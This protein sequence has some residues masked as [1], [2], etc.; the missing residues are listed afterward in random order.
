LNSINQTTQ[1]YYVARVDH[2]WSQETKMFVRSMFT[3][4]QVTSTPQLTGWGV[5]DPNATENR[6]SRHNHALNVTHLFSPAFFLSF[7]MG[8]SRFGQ[9]TTS[10]GCCETDFAQVL[11]IPNTAAASFPYMYYTGGLVPVTSVGNASS[12]RRVF[13][14]NIEWTGNLT[15]IVGNH[16]LKFGA[17]HSRHQGNLARS[18]EPSMNFSPGAKA[19]GPGFD[20]RFTRGITPTGA[21]VANTGLNLADFLLGRMIGV[22]ATLAPIFGKRI[23]Y[24][25]GYF[26]DDWRVTPRLTLNLG[27]R[28]DTETPMYE[29][30]DRYATFLPYAPNPLAGTGDI[31]AGATGITLFQNRNGNGK[32]LTNWDMTNF[33]PRFGFAYRLFGSNNTSLR[34]GFGLYYGGAGPDAAE[35]CGFNPFSITYTAA[36]PV[37]FRLRDGLP[38]GV[39]ALPGESELTPT[40][41]NRGTRFEQGSAVLSLDTAAVTPYSENFNLTVQ[42]QW[43]GILFEVGYRGNLSRQVPLSSFTLN[44][45][46]KELLSHTEIPA[47]LRRPWTVFASDEAEVRYKNINW[48]VANY[49]A[50]IFKSEYRFRNG[51]G[52]MVA[53]TKAKQLDNVPYVSS[54]GLGDNDVP[55]D[56]NNRKAEKSRSTG[57]LAHRLVFAPMVDLPFGKGRRW[58]N[59][60]GV[61]N[62]VLGGWQI[63]TIGTLQ[64]GAPF[65]VS[66]LN[67]GRDLLGDSLASLRPDLLRD[68]NSSSQGEPAVGVRGLQWLDPSAFANPARFT[69]GNAARTLPGVTGPGMVTFDSMVA[70][71]FHIAERWRI[72]FRWETFNTFNTPTFAL[73]AQDFGGGNF[74][75]VTSAGGRRIMQFGMKLYW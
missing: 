64:S 40:F 43:K 2:D 1:D 14:N 30:V 29:V 31:P 72:Q 19:P 71:N 67:G 5:A 25:G 21:A 35:D 57:N 56:L 10:G 47:R 3:K 48:G 42:H 6:W 24:Y 20:G 45:I 59:T 12:R 68:P 50:F 53:Y 9:I 27:L 58:M 51:I 23:E 4:P 7:S 36:H 66:V 37:P 26:Q 44:R 52:W 75:V 18:E 32:Y 54:T 46:P 41:G 11:G 16:T 17:Q 63:A 55:Q 15:R 33:A 74:G 65:G 69:Y 73:P 62:A 60:G 70:K 28:Y 8:Y 49:H 34:G 22:T 13:D 39:L 61:L 38:S